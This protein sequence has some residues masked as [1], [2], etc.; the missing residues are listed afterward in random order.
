MFKQNKEI[1]TRR[2]EQL[3]MKMVEFKEDQGFKMAL[4]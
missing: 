4:N 3:I 1:K 2:Q